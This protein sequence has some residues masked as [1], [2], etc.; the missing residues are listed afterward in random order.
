MT[1]T[2][3]IELSAGTV[4][5]HES[6]DGPPIVF[7]H[8]LLVDSTLWR[9]VVPALESDYRCV[10]P[11]LP[12]GSHAIPMN[13]D[14]DLTPAG[15]ATLIGELLEKL[16]LHDVT[17]VANDTG[18]ALTQILLASGAPATKRVGR[19]VLTPCDS[20]ENFLPPF[21]KPL[22]LLSRVPGGANAALQPLR[23]APLRRLPIAFGWLAKRSVPPDV[24]R[25]WLAPALQSRAIRRDVAKT[26]K[27]VDKRYTVDA[28]KRLNEFGGPV[29]IAWAPEDRFFP[30]DHAYE[31]AKLFPDA[32]VEEIEDSYTYVPE[33]QPERLVELLRDFVPRPAPAGSATA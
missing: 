14:A 31:L 27:G 15:Q 11:D 26:L 21:F 25:A 24:S 22:Q 23:L 32:R 1:Q 5:V 33:D 17:L 29:L 9:K 28:A 30:L 16:D 6:G 20:F 10:L 8:G 12:L 3:E 13:E 7:V 19:V 2:R 4:R 18:G